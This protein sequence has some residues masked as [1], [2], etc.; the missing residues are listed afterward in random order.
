M[1]CQLSYLPLPQTKWCSGRGQWACSL[2]DCHSQHLIWLP[3]QGS[4]RWP[5]PLFPHLLGLKILL[6]SVCV[7][8]FYVFL[9][10]FSFFVLFLPIWLKSFRFSKAGN[11]S[12][13][14]D[15]CTD[16]HVRLE[17]NCQFWQQYWLNCALYR[18]KKKK[19]IALPVPST[20]TF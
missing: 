9:S 17:L 3:G 7:V 18:E 1:K 2:V 14:N 10:I 4:E 6:K 19:K 16:F 11:V 13:V 15:H 8:T 20:G 5:Y 12:S